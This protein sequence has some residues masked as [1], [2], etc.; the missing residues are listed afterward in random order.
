MPKTSLFV[1]TYALRDIGATVSAWQRH[2]GLTDEQVGKTLGC[3]ARTWAARRSK[4]KNITIA[5]F[6]K[7]VR[8][9]QIPMEEAERCLLAGLDAKRWEKKL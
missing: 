7:L 6:W 5:E 2:R 8:L 9:F 3:C 1:E 4:P